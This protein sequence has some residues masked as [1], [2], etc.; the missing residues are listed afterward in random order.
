VPGDVSIVGFDDLPIA[1]FTTPS[2]TTVMHADR[3]DGGRGREAP[4]SDEDKDGDAVPVQVMRPQIVIRDSS[5]PAPSR[6]VLGDAGEVARRDSRANSL[7]GDLDPGRT[8]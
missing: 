5:G 4:P 7:P 2:L 6:L 1:E 8:R 3:R